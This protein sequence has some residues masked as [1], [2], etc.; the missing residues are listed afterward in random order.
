MEILRGLR[1]RGI[2]LAIDDFGTGYSSLSY[3]RRFPIDCLKIDKSF[4][5]D[6][7]ENADGVAIAAA[8]IAMGQSLNLQVVAEGVETEGQRAFLASRG[9]PLCQGYLF[10]PPLP[11]DELLPLLQ[12]GRITP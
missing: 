3:L 4:I 9:C 8:I 10:S 12:E 7:P 2:T 5:R 6:T 11:V 1:Q